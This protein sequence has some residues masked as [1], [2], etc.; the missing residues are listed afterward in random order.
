MDGAVFLPELRRELFQKDNPLVQS[1]QQCDGK[2]RPDDLHRHRRKSR[3]GA[4]IHQAPALWQVD[5]LQQQQAVQKVLFTDL[6]RVGDGSQVHLFVVFHQELRI[7]VKGRQL[8]GIEVDPNARGQHLH[9]FSVNH[10]SPLPCC[11]SQISSTEISAG[12]TPEIRLAC[13]RLR[14][15]MRQSFSTA[16]SRSPRIAV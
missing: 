2:I 5:G 4:D 6:C 8:S 16:S 3:P 10:R 12:L 15:R 1:V 14:G 9:L 7:A 11:S 13:P